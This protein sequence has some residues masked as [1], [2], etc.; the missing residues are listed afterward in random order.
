VTVDGVNKTSLAPGGGGT[1]TDASLC[2][3]GG[4]SYDNKAVGNHPANVNIP[5]T[6]VP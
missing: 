1:I 6:P 4:A 2:G 3:L 5:L